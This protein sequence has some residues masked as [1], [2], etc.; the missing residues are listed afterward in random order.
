MA[1]MKE[2]E[3]LTVLGGM[4]NDAVSNKDRF[5]SENEELLRRYKGELYG[6]EVPGRSSVVAN[7]VKDTVESDMPS[8]VRTFLGSGPIMKFQPT[9]PSNQD[10]VEE[11]EEKSAYVDWLIRGQQD[12]FRVQHGFLK[13]NLIQKMGVLKYFFEE[14]KNTEEHSFKGVDQFELQEIFD[15]LK[16]GSGARTVEITQQDQQVETGEFDITFKVT[17]ERQEIKIIGVPTESFLLSQNSSDIDEAILVGDEVSK[18]RGELLAEGF[19][20]KEVSQLSQVSSDPNDR[21]TMNQ[22]RFE[23][24]GGDDDQE[25]FRQWANELVQIQDLYVKVDFDGDGIAER[26][27]IQRSGDVILVNEAF[28]HVPYAMSSA[29]LMPHKAI[30]QGRAEQVTKTAAIKTALQRQMLDNGYMV[31]N[32][33]FGVNANVNLD[34]VLS[35]KIGGVV[36]VKGETNP[37]QNVFPFAVPSIAQ[38]SLL[39]LQHMD[40]LKAAAV[41]TQMASQGLNADQIGKETAT[42]FEGVEQ[43]AMAKIELVARVIAEVGYRKLYTGIAWM[44][45]RFQDTEREF[46]VLGKG[47]KSNPSKWK[48]DH[49]LVSEVGLGAGD[50]EAIVDNMTGIYNVQ[51][52]LL[53]Q[54]SPLVDQVKIFNT[55]NKLTNALELK[56]TSQFFNDPNE[57]DQ[58]LLAQN[59]QLNQMVLTLQQ[60]LQAAQNPLAEAEAVKRE[61]EIAIAQGKLQLEAAKLEEDRRQF[62]IEAAQ[63]GRQHQDD[64]ALKLTDME[65]KSGKNVPGSVV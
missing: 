24:E 56:D 20:R 34:D 65:L 17:I 7:D 6:N 3:L 9:N 32:P 22:I 36:R 44:V 12:S 18:T 10:E 38:E 37:G 29:L 50:N 48:F 47:L 4:V 21:S 59:E 54:G 28:D 51:Q 42:R 25:A 8:L 30:G 31:N 57:P 13:D 1:K 58:L 62:D 33:K 35:D 23:D 40:Q 26:R 11:A 61:G 41:G 39:L 14:T 64:T 27:H 60:Q 52:Q 46:S 49:Q 45:T 63:K 55:L 43:A 15:S 19:S 2:H 16:Q 53:A 5:I